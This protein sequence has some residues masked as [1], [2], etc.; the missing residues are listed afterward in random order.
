MLRSLVGVGEAS[1]VT[2]APT[3]IADMFSARMRVRAL[4][5]YYIAVP[6]GTAMGYGVGAGAAT[7]ANETLSKNY[8][9]AHDLMKPWRFALRV[10]AII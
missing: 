4:S 8:T 5:I 10:C 1:Y 9:V 3:I 2:V 6:V 7:I